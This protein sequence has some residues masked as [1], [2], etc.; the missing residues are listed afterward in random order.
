[1]SAVDSLRKFIFEEAMRIMKLHEDLEGSTMKFWHGGNLDPKAMTNDFSQKG[2]RYEY[3]PG[4][5][6]TTHYDTALKYAKGSRKLYIVEVNPGTS[7][8]DIT[9]SLEDALEAV[10]RLATPK[11]RVEISERLTAR[12]GSANTVKA[13]VVMNNLLNIRGAFKPN[14]T[15]ELRQWL[16]SIGADYE[17][18]NSPFGWGET[19]LVL[20]NTNK[21]RNVR[22]ATKEDGHDDFH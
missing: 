15:A 4:L 3:G 5:Y 19:M 17:V 9:I 7:L 8:D 6:L 12:Y 16:I 18:V 21:I 22:Q 14:K 11:G 13:S 10:K 2:G 20:Y 1:M